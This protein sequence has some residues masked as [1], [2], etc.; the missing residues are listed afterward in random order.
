MLYI[1]LEY[2]KLSCVVYD[3]NVRFEI[4]GYLIGE[5]TKSGR[6]N[7]YGE[8]NLVKPKVK[9]VC[10]NFIKDLLSGKANIVTVP[11]RA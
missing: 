9:S 5:L 6:I 11:A 1:S 3:N 2:P 7:W 10:K 8:S 4:E